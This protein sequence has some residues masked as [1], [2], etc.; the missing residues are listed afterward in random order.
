MSYIFYVTVYIPNNFFALNLEELMVK[1]SLV[2]PLQVLQN[3]LNHSSKISLCV[4]ESEQQNIPEK[5]EAS[6]NSSP[7][8]DVSTES[9]LTPPES[10]S[11]LHWLADLAEQKAREE[12]KGKYGKIRKC[13]LEDYSLT[14]YYQSFLLE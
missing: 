4:P 6:G 11:P 10:Q 13:I 14:K 8:S 7:R 3:V 2:W 12:K 5:S 1:D 9:K